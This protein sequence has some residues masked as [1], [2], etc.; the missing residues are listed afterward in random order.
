LELAILLEASAHKPGNVNIVTNFDS[1]RYEHFLASA[2]AA[3]PSFEQAAERG[4]AV[5]AGEVRPADAGIGRIIRD[6]VS[7]VNV[8][9]HGGNTLLGT[10]ILLVPIAAAAGA[11]QFGDQAPEIPKL[12]KRLK[13]MIESTTPGDAVNVYEAIGIASPAGLGAVPEFDINDPNSA[14][15]ILGEG[16]SLYSVFKMAAGYDTV[17]SEWVNNYPITFDL[18]YPSLSKRI[19]KGEDS[20]K[21]IVSSFLE[22]LSKVPDTFIARKAGMAKAREVS[23]SAAKVLKLGGFETAEGRR[24]LGV[25]DRSLREEGNLLNPGT[26][27]DVM[28]AALSLCVL[29]GYRP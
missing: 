8:W 29:G 10:I 20:D 23:A 15:R 14:S 18:A 19:A 16:V 6:C 25:F 11:T 12:R 21:A 4:I 5:S 27:A 24:S 13:L 7:R 22:I 3:A 9:Q 17:C 2:V 28:A 1:T 26:T